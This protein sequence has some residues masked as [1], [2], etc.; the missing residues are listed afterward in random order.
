MATGSRPDCRRAQQ[1][2][3]KCWP[4][5]RSKMLLHAW[6]DDTCLHFRVED[7]GSGFA[8]LATRGTGLLVAER[9]AR[10][11]QRQGK[12]GSLTLSNNGT[13]GGAVFEL[14]LPGMNRQPW[15]KLTTAKR[16][17]SSMTSHGTGKPARHCPNSRRLAVDFA[18][19]IRTPSSRSATTRRT[20]SLRP[21]AC[22]GRS[23]S[24]CRGTSAA[25]TCCRMKPF[26]MVTGEQSYEQVVAAVELVPDDYIIAI[27]TRQAV[28][29]A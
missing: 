2:R 21:H 23:G 11:H 29:C 4:H 14:C 16:F 28:Y 7:D 8:D 6:N 18:P 27:F 24:N 22:D 1:C 15:Q 20:S 12:H 9:I 26:L 10:L 3:A 25:S 5:A 19:A 13:L 17:R